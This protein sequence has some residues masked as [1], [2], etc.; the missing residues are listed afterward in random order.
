MIWK[1]ASIMPK[2]QAAP[3]I[4]PRYTGAHTFRVRKGET[5]EIIWR[6]PHSMVRSDYEEIQDYNSINGLLTRYAPAGATLRSTTRHR[7]LAGTVVSNERGLAI[8][9]YC[10]WSALHH[11]NGRTELLRCIGETFEA[12]IE[13][14]SQIVRLEVLGERLHQCYVGKSGP[15]R[16]VTPGMP[17]KWND[18]ALAK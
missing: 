6:I 9:S 17:I 2:I 11:Q 5:T 18:R 14:A 13:F 15:K 4:Y 1:K 3:G 10:R 7:M 8:S 12:E 16:K